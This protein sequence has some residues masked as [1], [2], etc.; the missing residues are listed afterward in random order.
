VRQKHFLSTFPNQRDCRPIFANEFGY[1]GIFSRD[2]FLE[3]TGGAIDCKRSLFCGPDSYVVM[4]PVEKGSLMNMVAVKR[5][6]PPTPNSE[7]AVL[8]HESDWIQPVTTDIMV[9]DFA[10]WGLPIKALISHIKRPER[11]ALYDHLSAP[12]YVKGR[13][14]L[15]GDSAHASTPHQ[16]QGAEMA[17][18]DS[19]ILSAI[20]GEIL[21]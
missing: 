15:L 2:Q 14:A 13:V 12:T 5:I 9:S 16:G 1:R 17:F 10:A 18:E 19:F 6:P 11:W 8:L 3:I 20:M 7:F 21:K 4:Y